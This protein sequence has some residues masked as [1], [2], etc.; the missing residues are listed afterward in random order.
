ME[1]FSVFIRL[2]VADW[3]FIIDNTIFKGEFAINF[4]WTCLSCWFPLATRFYCISVACVTKVL[5]VFCTLCPFW[6]YEVSIGQSV[7]SHF[8]TIMIRTYT[9][10]FIKTIVT[11]HKTHTFDAYAANSF[12]SS[13]N[14]ILAA[15]FID[16]KV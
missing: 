1:H 9:F 10:D 2:F 3:F 13:K 5:L 16:T 6:K 7:R 15:S 4:L 14:N 8:S 12:S 11:N